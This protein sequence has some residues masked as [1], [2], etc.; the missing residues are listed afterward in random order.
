MAMSGQ[1]MYDLFKG[2]AHRRAARIFVE[3]GAVGGELNAFT[4]KEHT[5][6]YTHTIDTGLALATD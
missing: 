6:F 1:E 2:T 3:I 5:C 4:A